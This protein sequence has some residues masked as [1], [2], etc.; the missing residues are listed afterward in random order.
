MKMTQLA[1]LIICYDDGQLNFRGWQQF[2]S[3]CSLIPPELA[4]MGCHHDCYAGPFCWL[5]PGTLWVPFQLQMLASIAWHTAPSCHL[6]SDP[7]R[8]LGGSTNRCLGSWYSPRTVGSFR[9]TLYEVRDR[10]GQSWRIHPCTNRSLDPWS[11]LLTACRR[12]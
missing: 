3:P 11:R 12:G 2:A 8:I 6:A 1:K 4:R 10:T 7:E 9:R 5:P